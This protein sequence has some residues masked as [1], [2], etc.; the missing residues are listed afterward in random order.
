MPSRSG[1]SLAQR[2]A[3]A[4][5]VAVVGADDR[6]GGLGATGPHEAREAEDLALVQLVGLETWGLSEAQAQL[7]VAL[8]DKPLSSAAD[9]EQAGAD[10]LYLS[11][12]LTNVR[13]A[14]L[15][16][17]HAVWKT[18]T[19]RDMLKAGRLP[20]HGRARSEPS[21]PPSDR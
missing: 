3:G 18:A 16:A 19:A 6:A 1:A 9:L 20:K 8:A 15:C 21:P 17:K 13:D 4:V 11:L 10:V 2:C 14:S 12:N 5:A 7:Y